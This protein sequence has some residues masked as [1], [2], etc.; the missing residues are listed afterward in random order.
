MLDSLQVSY[1]AHHIIQYYPIIAELTSSVRLGLISSRSPA[2]AGRGA[3]VPLA[4]DVNKSFSTD[5]SFC[6]WQRSMCC[7]QTISNKKAEICWTI[8]RFPIKLHAI[9]WYNIHARRV[10]MVLLW[11]YQV[12]QSIS[13]S[14]IQE[15]FFLSLA[16][17]W[18]LFDSKWCDSSI[19]FSGIF[20]ITLL[21]ALRAQ[22]WFIGSL[23]VSN[24]VPAYLKGV[25]FMLES[26]ILSLETINSLFGLRCFLSGFLS[27]LPVNNPTVQDHCCHG[28][29]FDMV[30]N[31]GN[32]WWANKHFQT[33]KSNYA[34]TER[35]THRITAQ[36]LIFD[37]G[38]GWVWDRMAVTLFSQCDRKL[39]NS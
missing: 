11:V 18:K 8:E 27:T 15:G 14:R 9:Q 33:K 25:N 1:L 36:S 12:T 32:Q 16:M 39:L 20:I 2:G 30:I 35:S 3:A 38:R 23:I 28:L 13:F 10:L 37:R 31:T 24:C 19:I 4:C 29:M 7:K 34:H 22:Y 17:G 21:C 6:K 26:H 5:S